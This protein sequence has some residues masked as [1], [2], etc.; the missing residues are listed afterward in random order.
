[1]IHFTIPAMRW[2]GKTGRSRQVVVGYYSR[3]ARPSGERLEQ[4][5]AWREHI[6]YHASQ[7]GVQLPWRVTKN[8]RQMVYIVAY[9][10]NGNHPDVENVRKGIVD[11]LVYVSKEMKAL[12]GPG[13]GSDKWIGGGHS[14]PRY[15]KVKPRAEVYILTPEEWL[16]IFEERKL[17]RM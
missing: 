3:G 13:Y 14:L 17:C 9:F 7:A 15:D 1:M 8:S 5:F 11:A 12:L 6:C 10:E 4:Y 2:I 16:E